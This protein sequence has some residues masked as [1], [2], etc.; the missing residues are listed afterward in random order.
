MKDCGIEADIV[1][2]TAVID[3]FKRAKN[4]DKCW[5]IFESVA[6]KGFVDKSENGPDEFLLSYMVR[7]CAATSNCEM[8][9]NLFNRMEKVGYI[10]NVLNFNS[11]IFA[12]GSRKDY[13]EDAI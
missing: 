12:L 4:I 6:Q 13:A 11:L 1:T 8:A 5:E 2:V 7:L 10:P 3:A 9:I